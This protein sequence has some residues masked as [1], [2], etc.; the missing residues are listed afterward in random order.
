METI[1]GLLAVSELRVGEV[2]RLTNSDVGFEQGS[3]VMRD[4][5]SG[6]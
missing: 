3:L 5:K 1:V 4:S 6:V 2:I